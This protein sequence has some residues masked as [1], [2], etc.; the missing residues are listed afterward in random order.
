MYK[1]RKHHNLLIWI[2]KIKTDKTKSVSSM[3]PK[4]IQKISNYFSLHKE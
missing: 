3:K 1:K 4:D 2:D